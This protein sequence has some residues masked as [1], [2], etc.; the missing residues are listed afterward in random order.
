[1]D[2]PCHDALIDGGL[3]GAVTRGWFGVATGARP[4]GRAGFLTLP[5]VA[6]FVEQ[7]PGELIDALGEEGALDALWLSLRT[8]AAAMV[9]IVGIGTPAAYFLAT[10][11]FRG[12]AR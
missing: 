5:I 3:R 8:T 7:P 11:R 12:A 6:L 9:L 2:G 10:R 4:R 1:M